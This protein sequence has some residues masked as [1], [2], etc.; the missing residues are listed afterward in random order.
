MYVVASC[1]A[2]LPCWQVCCN[3]LL[4]YERVYVC[5]PLVCCAACQVLP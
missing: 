1:T 3:R 2:G 5:V 4:M